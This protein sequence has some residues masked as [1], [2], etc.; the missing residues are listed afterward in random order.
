MYECAEIG[1]PNRVAHPGQKC[2]ACQKNAM[3]QL[4]DMLRL[5]KE[6][7][8]DAPDAIVFPEKMIAQQD[9]HNRQ[10][11]ED[12][13]YELKQRLQV[14]REL[15][16]KA[17]GQ[18]CAENIARVEA[19]KIGRQSLAAE[20]LAHLDRITSTTAAYHLVRNLCLIELGREPD[21]T[22]ATI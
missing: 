22:G 18:V 15:L 14:K 10:H 4:T 21:S 6:L 19:T 11:C 7:D 9:V 8:P 3:E 13:V 1:C 2:A 5:R 12:E 17:M 20:L 16:D